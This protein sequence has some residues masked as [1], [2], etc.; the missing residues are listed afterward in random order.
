VTVADYFPTLDPRKEP[1]AVVDLKTFNHYANRHS[2]RA[3]GGSNELWVSLADDAPGPGAVAEALEV[4]GIRVREAHLASRMVSQRVEQPLVSGGWRGLLVLVFLALV[5]ANASGVMLFSYV[6]TRERQTEFALLRT[7]GSSPGQLNGVVWFNLILVV[8]CGIGL[9]TW[10]GQQLGNALLPLLGVA[11][12]GVP[13][14]PPMVLQTNWV[15][16]LASYLILGGV[17]AGTVVWLAW[18]TAKLE[19]QRVLRVGEV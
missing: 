10:A 8:A 6:D 11:E 15:V 17:T 7:L 19:V 1:F 9:G 2:L 12:E 4:N 18:L 5:L 3:A 13:A 14:T 16:L